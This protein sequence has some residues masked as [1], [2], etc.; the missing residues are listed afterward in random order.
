MCTRG[1]VPRRMALAGQGIVLLTTEGKKSLQ[2]D[3][4]GGTQG[5]LAHR[6]AAEIHFIGVHKIR[7]ARRAAALHT[8]YQV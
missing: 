5:V 8:F 6:A 4:V 1:D 3:S 7:I 2:R